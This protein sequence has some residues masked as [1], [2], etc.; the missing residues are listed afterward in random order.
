[1]I[2]DTKERIEY[3]TKRGWWGDKTMMDYLKETI[4]CRPEA[5]ALVDPPNRNELVGGRIK[6]YTYSELDKAIERV[7]LSLL[8]LGIKKDDIIM[9]QVPNVVELAVCYFAFGRI[10]AIIS[11]VP[12]QYRRHELRYTMGHLKPKAFV[13]VTEFNKFS[14]LEMAEDMAKEIRSLDHIIVVGEDVS[15][16]VNSFEEMLNNK[17]LDEKYPVDY[18]EDHPYKQ[19]ANEVWTICWTSGTE[20]DPKAVPRTHNQWFNIGWGL[21]HTPKLG[22]GDNILLPFPLIN[23]AAI[24]SDFIPW[25]L[26]GGKLVLHHPFDPAIFVKQL[27]EEKINYTASAPAILTMLAQ[28]EKLLPSVDISA[29]NAIGV[30]SAPPSVWLINEYKDKYGVDIFNLWGANEGTLM[31]NNSTDIP[32]PSERAVYF[33]RWGTPGVRSS[34]WF[35]ERVETKLV[36]VEGNEVTEPGIAAEMWYKGPNVCASYYKQPEYTERAYKENWWYKT[37]D[38]F[39]IEGEQR[40]F[41]KFHGRSKDLIIRGGQ[42]ISPEEVENLALGHPKVGDAAAIGVYDQRL[43]EKVCLYVAPIKGETVTIEEVVSFMREK[44]IAIYKLPEYLEIV[45]V[46]PRN[47]VGK[48]TKDAIRKDFAQKNK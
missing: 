36:D 14:H 16:D 1:M 20:A 48:I 2:L 40:Q 29:L 19:S 25:I 11:P 7:S 24:S 47:P 35:A 10:G 8:E 34:I 13:T 27:E 32:D 9:V 46:I 6:R 44:D 33:A 42:N 45:D 26:T 17:S 41:Y 38:L 31:C 22:I 30:G 12:I 15:K 3:Y 18:F 5:E 43:G 28:N 4:V 39:S 37:G 21:T 23:L